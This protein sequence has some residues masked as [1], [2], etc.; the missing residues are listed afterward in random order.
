MA[1]MI[2]MERMASSLATSTGWPPASRR[3]D[4]V[5]MTGLRIDRLRVEF[6]DVVGVD[7]VSLAVGPGRL[8]AFWGRTARG[9]P[10]RCERPSGSSGRS[11]ERFHGNG[12]PIDESARRRIG[13]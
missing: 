11:E 1:L 5:T 10:R 2:G 12:G 7:D 4:A 6:G 9:R 8:S 3:P 13:Y